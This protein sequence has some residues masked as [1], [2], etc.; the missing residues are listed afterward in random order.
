[1][2]LKAMDPSQI[3][4]IS[5]SMPKKMFREY[6]AGEHRR[7]G[8]DV[9]K[10]SKMLAR[11]ASGESVEMGVE[12][13]RLI[14][15]FKGGKKKRTFRLPLLDLGEGLERE[16]K[17]EYK[18]SVVINADALR[19]VLKDAKLV[20]THITLI[21]DEKKF[22]VEIKGDDGEI[23]EEFEKD[24]V[25]LKELK[26]GTPAKATYPLS[27]MEDMIKAA[28]SETEITLYLENDRPLKMEYAVAGA[29]A[30]YYLAPRIESA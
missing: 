16:P 14:L 28:K 27:Y 19:E 2:K 23:S 11:G 24:G 12:E 30:K 9:G 1:V 26:V 29:E 8:L 10:L 25:A 3:S 17:I 6:A 7:I 13:G 5:F 20:S 15:T 22:R 4:M 18:N 21:A